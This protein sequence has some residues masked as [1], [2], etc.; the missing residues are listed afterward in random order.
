MFITHHPL[1]CRSFLLQKQFIHL[2]LI[3]TPPKG[4]SLPPIFIN[5]VLLKEGYAVATPE[6]Y[7]GS[8]T[9]N[10]QNSLVVSKAGSSTVKKLAT[11]DVLKKLQSFRNG[12]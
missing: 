10:S 2:T 7:Y 12:V 3:E 5:D 1:F 9:N 11:K 4:S 6:V 8:T